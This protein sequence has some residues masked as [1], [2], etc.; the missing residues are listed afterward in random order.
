MD[1]CFNDGGRSEAGFKG[2]ADDCVCRSIAIATG[3]SYLEVYNGLN[4]F[5]Q[6][7]EAKK[8]AKR[9]STARTGVN[10][11][12]TRAYL[13]SLG[14]EWVPTMLIGQGCKIHLRSEELPSGNLIVKVSGHVTAVVDGVIHDTADPSREGTRCVYGYFHKPD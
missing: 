7:I 13:K 5:A 12:T 4:K 6:S 8:S 9:R 2:Y 14:W 1:F 10:P 11:K 3:N